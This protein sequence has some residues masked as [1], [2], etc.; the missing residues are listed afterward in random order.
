MRFLL[1][2][3]YLLQQQAAQIRVILIK[4]GRW[5]DK[6]QLTVDYLCNHISPNSRS[7]NLL[8]TLTF[9]EMVIFS[10]YCWLLEIHRCRRNLSF[11]VIVQLRVT[12]TSIGLSLLLFGSVLAIPLKFPDQHNAPAYSEGR[13]LNIHGA[14]NGLFNRLTATNTIQDE[15]ND[16]DDSVGGV[17]QSAITS[18]RP[19]AADIED[20]R[21]H[22]NRKRPCVP[23]TPFRSNNNVGR[24]ADQ[25]QGR[26]FFSLLW[27]DYNFYGSPHGS[28]QYDTYGGYPCYSLGGQ[29]T[30][31][32]QRPHRP[33]LEGTSP[34]GIS[35]DTPGGSGN[36]PGGFFGVVQSFLN[37][38][39]RPQSGTG[40]LSD[41]TN[42]DVKPVIELNV[43]DTVQDVVSQRAEKRLSLY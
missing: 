40:G 4:I 12:R 16:Y 15:V 43:Q 22:R 23:Y 27:N 10:F 6:Q 26:T 25:G 42:N 11:S 37:Q 32:P 20:R 31:R 33:H 21:R 19:S 13:F 29:Q 39:L 8:L 17:Q 1:S 38:W 3:I 35:N 30:H 36:L 24:Q 41:S 9:S 28:P 18:P 7:S 14:P 34:D 2:V 5:R